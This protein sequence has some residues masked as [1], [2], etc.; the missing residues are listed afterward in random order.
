M[1]Q[2]I[3]WFGFEEEHQK[4]TSEHS[5]ASENEVGSDESSDEASVVKAIAEEEDNAEQNTKE[6]SDSDDERLLF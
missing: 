5:E 2:N 4:M 1:F 6:P 3:L